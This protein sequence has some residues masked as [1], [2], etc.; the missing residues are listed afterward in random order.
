MLMKWLQRLALVA[1]VSAMVAG[2]GG[3]QTSQQQPSVSAPGTVQIKSSAQEQT[4]RFDLEAN[5]KR[6]GHVLARHVGKTDEELRQRL[7]Q[8]RNISAA[9][10]YPDRKTAEEAIAAALKQREEKVNGWL[11]RRRK[12]NLVLDYYATTSVGRTLRRGQTESF[13]CTHAIV[14]LKWDKT[15]YYVLTSYP[16]CR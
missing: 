5:E 1:A 13:P 4:P 14:V 10:T 16:E 9:S 11:R 15:D 6:G 3:E 7:E 12:P 8:E 2:C